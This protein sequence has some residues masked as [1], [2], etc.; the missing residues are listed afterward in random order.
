MGEF[1]ILG[2]RVVREAARSGSFSTA[3]ERLGYTQ[4]AVSR[5]IALME[6]A[7]GRELFERHARGVR[8]TAAGRIVVRHAEVVLGELDSARERLDRLDDRPTTVRVGAFST[9][10]AALIP[11]AIALTSARI[12]LREGTSP[13]LLTALGRGRLDLAVVTAADPIPG[14]VVVEHVVDD[15]LLVAVGPGH[16]LA[17][18]RSV[19]PEQLRDERWIA[20]SSE[21][22]G[23]LLGAWHDPHHDHDPDIAF[24]ARDWFA[25]LGLVAAGMGVTVVPGIAVPM[26]PSAVAVVRID[27]RAAM[28]RTVM[29]RGPQIS[30][31][32]AA[33]VDAVHDS[34]AGLAIEIGQRTRGVGT[35]PA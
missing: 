32:A 26:L 31:A 4:S 24:V 33:F 5:Q 9:A 3:A 11:R 20:G 14:D 18:Q 8:P 30:A 25:K 15:P 21:V 22:G 16:R 19:T 34:V 10:M 1:S 28:R 35:D 23:T 2:L 12:L 17:G 27:H 13:R 6:L 7:A 29:V